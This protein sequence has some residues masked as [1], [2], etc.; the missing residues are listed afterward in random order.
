MF[1]LQTLRIDAVALAHLPYPHPEGS[2]SKVTVQVPTVS[3]LSAAAT[4][5]LRS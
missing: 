4:V 2:D 5:Q 3:T 1:D